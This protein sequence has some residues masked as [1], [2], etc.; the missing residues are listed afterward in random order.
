MPVNNHRVGKGDVMNRNGV[1]LGCIDIAREV[2]QAGEAHKG[3]SKTDG[4]LILSL[5]PALLKLGWI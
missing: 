3:D 1:G 4:M 5:T 2:E